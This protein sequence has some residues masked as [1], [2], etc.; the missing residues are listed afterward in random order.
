MLSRLYYR[1]R[2]RLGK[3]RPLALAALRARAALQGM[4]LRLE[5]DRDGTRL[6]IS[7]EDR[8]VLLALHHYTYVQDVLDD[9]DYYFSAVECRVVAGV[10][11]VDFSSPAEHVLKPSGRRFWFTSLPEAEFTTSL[12]L[13]RTPLRAGAVVFDIGAYCG[14][15]SYHF[16]QLVGDRGQVFSFEPDGANFR[17]LQQNVRAHDLRNV[18]LVPKGVWSVTTTLSFQAESNLGSAIADLSGRQTALQT[19]SVLSLD[20]T[21]HETGIKQL[22]FVKLDVEGAEIAILEH[23]GEF[24]DRFRPDFVIE[25]HRVHGEM[26]TPRIGAVLRRYGYRCEV[27]PQ[28]HLRLPLIFATARASKQSQAIN[29]FTQSGS[30]VRSHGHSADGISR[31]PAESCVLG[32]QP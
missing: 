3:C 15:T 12:Y 18:T 5:A 22:D 29:A 16:A 8:A 27:L 14:A 19:V 20:D 31:A 32:M 24:W 9:F 7:C 13:E 28:A 1:L 25:P 30:T 21:I 11:V 6:R 2:T 23:A 26:T 17:A 10:R 4:R